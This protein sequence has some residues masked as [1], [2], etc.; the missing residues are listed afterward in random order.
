MAAFESQEFVVGL[1]VAAILLSALVVS[2]L[3]RN[4]AFALAAGGIVLLYVQGGVPSLVAMSNALESQ[5]RA[6][7]DFSRGLM[8][9]VAM[10]AVF[11]LGMRQRSS[12]S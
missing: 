12:S 2:S 5:L 7:P 11:L 6:I 10:A 1:G 4:I 9:G 3:F 8:V